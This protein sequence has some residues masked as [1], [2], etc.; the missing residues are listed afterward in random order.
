VALSIALLRD[1]GLM[2]GVLKMAQTE[3][4]QR[5]KSSIEGKE[6]STD[7]YVPGR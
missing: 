2:I 1:V 5:R 6:K 4:I 7:R 3:I